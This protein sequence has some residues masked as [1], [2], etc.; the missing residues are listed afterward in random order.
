MRAS[1]TFV[2]S[3]AVCVAATP[4]AFITSARADP[5]YSSD[6]VIQVFLKDKAAVDA[7]KSAPKTRKVCIGTPQ[8]CPAPSP[9]AVAHFDLLVNFD[10]NSDKL[11][12]AAKENLDQFAKALQ[13]PRLKRREIRDRRPHGRDRRGAIQSGAFGAPR[14]RGRL[15]LGVARP[16]RVAPDRQG[17]RQDE[18]ARRRP[19]QRGKP[20]GRNPPD[21]VTAPTLWWEPFRRGPESWSAGA[22]KQI[23]PAFLGLPI[24]RSGILVEESPVTR[25]GGAVVLTISTVIFCLCAGLIAWRLRCAER[26]SRLRPRRLWRISRPKALPSQD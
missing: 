24:S 21:G 26:T 12:Q 4:L 9:P 3:A 18:A 22:T 6:K 5:A 20:S 15:L 25:R 1:L 23:V 10:F 8:E 16:R 11:T 7:Y 17:F 19:L 14:E 13:D 2:V